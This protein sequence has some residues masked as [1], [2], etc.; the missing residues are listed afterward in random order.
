MTV[1]ETLDNI[2]KRNNGYLRTSD[3]VASG[4][5]KTYL[6]EY[7]KKRNLDRVAKGVYM[8]EDAWLD[9]L[10]LIHLRNKE[11]VFSH[12]TALYLY[13]LTDREP[14]KIMLTVSRG[15][16]ASHLRDRDCKVYT[17]SR[18]VHSLGKT[19]VTTNF[20][21]K[22]YAYDVDR[23]ICDIIKSKEKTDIQ[24]FQSALKEYMHSSNKNLPNLMKYAAALGI[25]D[26][27]RTYTEVML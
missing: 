24:V 4:I 22:V 6:S 21:N 17:I 8:T 1:Q 9:E 26:K 16:N 10:Y 2:V 11:A 7:V 19:E 23:T 18:D 27:V 5:S 20:G 25:E 3:V 15:Y 14:A 12:E 13:G